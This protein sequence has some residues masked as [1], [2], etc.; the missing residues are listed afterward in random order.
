[1]AKSIAE[2]RTYFANRMLSIR[3]RGGTQAVMRCGDADLETV[4]GSKVDADK[5]R[6]SLT[7]FAVYL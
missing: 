4:F 5:F 3:L 6:A 7:L 2:A 1:M